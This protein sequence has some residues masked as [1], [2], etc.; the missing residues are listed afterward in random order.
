[1]KM[2]SNDLNNFKESD[3]TNQ[4]FCKLEETIKGLSNEN[5]N[6]T[7]QSATSSTKNLQKM[8]QTMND[9]NKRVSRTD[10]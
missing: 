5:M 2:T 4:T 10:C 6:L 1:M 9:I 3:N 7:K 8:N